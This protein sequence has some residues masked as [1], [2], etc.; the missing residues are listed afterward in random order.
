MKCIVCEFRTES[1]VDQ[2]KHYENKHINDSNTQSVKNSQLQCNK[3]K[4]KFTEKKY[5]D[6]HVKSYHT[7]QEKL[8][9]CI[10]CKNVSRSETELNKH[11]EDKHI[12]NSTSTKDGNQLVKKRFKNGPLCS[13]LKA[14]RCSYLHDEPWKTA[15]PKRQTIRARPP[16]QNQDSAQDKTE[17]RNGPSCGWNKYNK[18]SFFHSSNRSNNINFVQKRNHVE[19]D[20]QNQ[21]ASQI[22]LKQCKWGAKCHKGL[23]CGFLHTAADFQSFRERRRH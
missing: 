12:N 15:L 1:E 21:D 19:S 3:C 17:C 9:K 5:L 4:D 18:C 2:N 23:S 16:V 20:A 8:F 13:Y 14:D 6:A 7:V 11:Y 22:Q 10:A